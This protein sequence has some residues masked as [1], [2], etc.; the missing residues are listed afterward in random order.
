MNLVIITRNLVA[1]GGISNSLKNLSI[2]WKNLNLNNKKDLSYIVL[3]RVDKDIL[4]EIKSNS[5]KVIVCSYSN[6]SRLKQFF[7]VRKALRKCNYDYIICTCFRTYLFAKLSVPSKKIIMWFRGAGYLNS[8]IKKFLFIFTNNTVS[9]VNSIYTANINNL[10]KY[11]VIYNGVSNNFLYKNC[12]N[13]HDDFCISKGAKVIGFIGNWNNCKNHITLVRA[14]NLIAEKYKDIYLICIG[15]HSIL[16]KS[17]W[18]EI[19]YKDKVRFK[20][21]MSYAA[22]Y[23][24]Y[25]SVYV[26]P[27]CNEGFGNTV[28]EAMYADCP[29]IAA[30]SGASPEIIRNNI[31]GLLY[32]P[33]TSPL[34]CYYAISKV[35]NNDILAKKLTINARMRTVKC[36]SAEAFA[37]RF[38][39]AVNGNVQ[40]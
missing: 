27:S 15:N 5:I 16:T 8:L 36:F 14:F 11:R 13:F 4:K 29:V 35:L 17:A 32:S 37:R 7:K 2:G 34:H 19:K 31:D 38:S 28:I 33:P 20:D 24:K 3:E 39:S 26:Q 18:E 1:Y 23:I 40:K 25:F 10:D 21:K 9:F 30:R 22:R 6:Q 12:L